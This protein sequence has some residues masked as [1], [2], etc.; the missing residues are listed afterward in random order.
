MPDSRPDFAALDER[1]THLETLYTHQQRALQELNEVL[2]TNSRQ[3]DALETR[4]TQLVEAVRQL[5]QALEDVR[6]PEQE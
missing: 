3:V 4:V 5:R 6:H 1:I 2:V